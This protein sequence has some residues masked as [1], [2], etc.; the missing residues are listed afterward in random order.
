MAQAYSA[1]KATLGEDMA[2]GKVESGENDED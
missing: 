1:S 2:L